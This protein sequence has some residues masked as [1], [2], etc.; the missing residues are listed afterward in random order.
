[1]WVVVRLIVA[2]L[3]GVTKYFWRWKSSGEARRTDEINWR[4][5]QSK[6]KNRVVSTS[7]GVPCKSPIFFRLSREGRLDRFFKQI[8]FSYEFETGDPVLDAMV[9]ISCDHLALEPILQGDD[10][11]RAAI[12]ELFTQGA[13]DVASDGEH[14]W[15]KFP[16]AHPPTPAKA[17]KLATVRAALDSV[18]A[19]ELALLGD[20]FFWRALLVEA[21]AWSIALYAVPSLFE[22]TTRQF[23]QYL[24][25]TPIVTAGL[26]AAIPI[27]ALLFGLAWRIL[28]GSSRAHRVLTESAVLLLIGVPLS[29]IQMVS[30]LNIH[31][32][33]SPAF[34]V[35]RQLEGKYTTTRRRKGTTT[36]YYHLR[37]GPGRP[38]SLSVP[39]EIE[40]GWALYNRFPDRGRIAFV[41]RPGALKIPWVE[42]IV[43]APVQNRRMGR[44]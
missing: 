1:M 28:R 7:F 43:P 19:G 41:L 27:F 23:P 44:P 2:I 26:V 14:L 29:S 33:R 30:D 4:Y 20:G 16:G 11:A 42:D 36:T 21:I 10:A 39:A 24:S 5:K 15:V 38:D 25:W 13:Q 35:E 37:I 18:P 32:D 8:G 3:V 9:Y 12:L 6:S 40:V 22:V 17:I 34:V 31:L